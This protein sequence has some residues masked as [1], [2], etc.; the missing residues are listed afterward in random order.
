[1]ENERAVEFFELG[2]A[3]TGTIEARP[4]QAEY[5]DELTERVGSGE[6]HKTL[7]EASLAKCID[8]RL[9]TSTPI[10]AANSAGGSY[11]HVVAE[12]LMHDAATPFVELETRVFNQLRDQAIALGVHTDTHAHG[13]K[14][15]CGADDRLPEIFA[16][17]S[18]QQEAVRQ[19]AEV[20]LGQIIDDEMH[21]KLVE[22]AANRSDFGTGAGNL[23]A[24][25]DAGAAVETLEGDHN[26]VLSVI[27]L[28]GNTTLDREALAAEF[29]DHQVFN[30][31]AWAFMQAAEAT[32]ADDTEALEKIVAL[33]YY[34]F[35]TALVLAGPS[36]RVTILKNDVVAE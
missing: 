24:A 14:S 17:I 23:R 19:M 26:E 29:P 11:S 3:A 22:N 10:D 13:D 1:M 35:A 2:A 33:T 6:F 15:G 7:T 12:A 36:M 34:N 21:R 4:D 30:I 32:A 27:N 31:D 20:T 8:G 25:K 5:L 16:K 28:R 18:D 9:D